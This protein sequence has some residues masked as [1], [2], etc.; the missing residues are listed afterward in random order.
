MAVVEARAIHRSYTV[1]GVPG[2]KG[3]G[4]DYRGGLSMGFILCFGPMSEQRSYLGISFDTS[5]S[6][7]LEPME[8]GGLLGLLA[9]LSIS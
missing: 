3:G 1:H 9:P 4:R 8:K 5:N 2:R 7:E 6:P